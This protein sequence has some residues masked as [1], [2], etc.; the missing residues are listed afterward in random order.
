[1]KALTGLPTQAYV[2]VGEEANV[3]LADLLRLVQELETNSS[4]AYLARYRPDVSAGL[5]AERIEQVQQRLRSFLDLSDRRITILTAIGQ[6][7]RLTPELRERVESALDRRELEDLYLPFK[8][9]RRSAADE[10]VE[11]N[12]EG[13]ARFLWTQESA[14]ADVEQEA[15]QYVRG[16]VPDTATALHGGRE[17]IARWLTENAEIRRDLRKIARA[18]SEL[19]VEALPIRRRL[20][21]R[22]EQLRKKFEN[23][24]GLRALSARIPWRQMLSIRRGAREGFLQYRL[25]LPENHCVQ[26][27]L[28]R[29]L[30]HAE[31]EFTL[32]LGAAA[33][34]AFHNYL[35]P[36]V[37]SELRQELEERCDDQ[38]IASYQK[39]LA[40]ML[41][42]PPAGRKP[43]IGI[44][45]GRP[46]GWRAAVIGPDGQLLEAAIVKPDPN[47][48][49]RDEQEESAQDQAE[50]V[51]AKQD[52][53]SADE[54]SAETESNSDESTAPAA[55]AAA[56]L[57]SQEEP[58]APEETAEP[59]AATAEPAAEDA[60]SEAAAEEPAAEE[61]AAEETAEAEAPA[62]ASA[63]EAPAAAEAPAPDAQTE[64]PPAAE[65]APVAEDKPADET[66]AAE[67]SSDAQQAEAADAAPAEETPAQ[68]EQ[69]VEAEQKGPSEKAPREKP[70]DK[71]K[72]RGDS[73]PPA[74]ETP[75][76][77]LAQLIAKHKVELIVIGNGPGL[78]QVE[79][80]V[81]LAIKQSGRPTTARIAINEAGSW[82]YA[83]SKSARRE[84]PQY[85][86]AVRSAA[87]LA[88]RVQNPLG[89]LVKLDPRVLGIGQGHH[90]VDQKKLRQALQATAESCVHAAG[91]DVN[92]API[93][94]LS[95]A[96]GM[97]E[98][99]ARRI[100]EQRQKHGP[101]ADREALRRTAG[102][103]ERIFE[104]AAG[105]LR[106]YGGSNPLDTTGVHP[107]H[108]EKLGEL[109]SAAGLTA[110][111]AV[112]DP[113]KL[114]ELDIKPFENKDF[115]LPVLEAIVRELEPA[116]RNP[117]GEF[118]PPDPGDEVEP[119]DEPK[120]GMQ[121][122]GVITNV[123]GFGAFVDIG[124]EQDG[125][126]H[127]SQMTSEQVR[128]GQ[129]IV[130][131]GEKITV[132]VTH[133]NPAENRISLSMH[134]VRESS[135]Q[136]RVS[137][138]ARDA[139][140]G[141]RPPRGGGDRRRRD[142]KREPIRRTF[143]P[144]EQARK[145]E[146]E[147]MRN[148]SIDDKLSALN[149]KFR[150]KV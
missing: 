72:G 5:D 99:V 131:P 21:H 139:A 73:R 97:T 37:E 31:S 143:G 140:S 137:R 22:D 17:I 50:D 32:Q 68:A 42:A 25:V 112:A 107:K 103:N 110:E 133:V 8:P 44:E 61:P 74:I 81:R 15:Q 130:K 116:V 121:V 123:T 91:V 104:Q 144:D 138:E 48:R 33:R 148:M 105:F 23:L 128:D 54:A 135:R 87:C 60:P 1:M 53:S 126:V 20:S 134:A 12:L 28:S 47:R 18:E 43:V 36:G 124:A 19:V 24:D 114:L 35:A 69:P 109:L 88:R 26:Y 45:T 16:A 3:P 96:P 34:L 95:L 51:E 111:E 71:K 30:R 29:L 120:V 65:A 127:V 49:T 89:E 83:T 115:S 4:P 41:L 108:Y 38:A 59:E 63:E 82:I 57:A 7:D 39:N 146:E 40:K 62:E 58:V 119:I 11:N 122:N 101:F 118:Q 6:Q 77:D 64:E 9:K 145:A 79:R 80:F 10:A 13:L 113:A 100:V 136:R 94:L 70:R 106:I 56:E 67:A 55:E 142:D 102:I 90:E 125:L 84:M 14:E 76:G 46:G 85:E 141:G 66:P 52:E 86:P 132:F 75:E 92:A 129:P 78:R 117:R 149:Q 150:T 2:Q 93:E 147:R 27:L 98:R